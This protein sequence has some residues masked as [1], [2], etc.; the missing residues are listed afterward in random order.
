MGTGK[1]R[2]HRFDRFAH[3]RG[4]PRFDA[5]EPRHLLS[6]V[7]FDLPEYDVPAGSTFDV[8]VLIDLD[9]VTPGDQVPP[10][11]LFSAGIR[12]TF[13][14]ANALVAGAEAVALPVDLDEN[15]LGG[16]ALVEVGPGF[17]GF[18]AAIGFSA[19]EGYMQTLLATITLTDRGSA[20]YPINLELFFDPPT[21]N[22]LD[23]DGTAL[24][25]TLALGSAIVRPDVPEIVL[26]DTAIAVDEGGAGIVNVT[27]SSAPFSVLNLGVAPGP[28]ADPD[29]RSVSDTLTFTPDDWDQP[30]PWIIEA[31]EDDDTEDG[32]TVFTISAP[33]LQPVQLTATERD[34]DVQDLLVSATDL[35]SAESDSTSFTVRLA[36]RPTA[37]VEVRIE[38][39]AGDDPDLNADT[40]LLTF[41]PDDWDQPRTVVVTGSADADDADGTARFDV[42]SDGLD[43]RTVTVTEIDDDEQALVVS[44]TTLTVGEG[45][46]EIV[47]VRLATQPPG[48]VTVQ[49]AR[50]SGDEGLSS[51]VDSVLLGAANWDQPQPVSILA[52]EDDDTQDG[53]ATFTFSAPDL[54][55]RNVNVTV[56]DND[57]Q[58]LI[59]SPSLLA[60]AED[61]TAPLSI[62]LAARPQDDVIVQVERRSGDADVSV[63]GTPITFTANNWFTAQ[64]V[65][66][67]AARDDDGV[68][69]I[70]TLAVIAE[71]VDDVLVVV[72]EV[73]DGLPPEIADQ[74]FAVTDGSAAGTVVGTVDA[75]D[76]DAGDVVT[77]D[78]AAGNDAGAFDIDPDGTLRL[79]DPDALAEVGL[80]TLTVRATDAAG[81]FSEAAV[82]IEIFDGVLKDVFDDLVG[83]DLTGAVT[84]VQGDDPSNRVAQMTEQSDAAIARLVDL[85]DDADR[86]S[87]DYLFSNRGDGDALSIT[88]D[89]IEVFRRV[90]I[91]FAGEDLLST[92]PI[93]VAA[94]AGSAVTLEVRLETTGA[95]GAQ[96]Q[97]DNLEIT[98]QPILTLPL[99]AGRRVMFTDGDGTDV[100]L[101]LSKGDGT[102]TVAGENL[103][104]I[105]E[106]RA[107]TIAGDDIEIVGIDLAGETERGVLQFRGRGGDGRIG[108]RGAINVDG[109]LNALRAGMVVFEHVI[110]T[111]GGPLTKLEAERLDHVRLFV[112]D[113]AGARPL[114]MKFDEA[115]QLHVASTVAM[116]LKADRLAGGSLDAPWF[117][118]L[119]VR[120][121][122]SFS[123]FATGEGAPRDVAV[124][125]GRFGRLVDGD[126]QVEGGAGAITADEI[127]QWTARFTGPVTSLKARRHVRDVDLEADSVRSVAAGTDMT[128]TTI[129]LTRD[130]NPDRPRDVAVRDLR[131]GDAMENVLVTA[132]SGI[133]SLQAGRMEDTVVRVG[134]A[135]TV[136]VGQSPVGPQDFV[137]AAQISSVRLRGTGEPGP[138]MRNVNLAATAIGR[139]TTGF[140]DAAAASTFTAGAFQGLS[141]RDAEGRRGFNRRSDVLTVVGDHLVDP[142][143]LVRVV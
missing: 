121:D 102:L 9:D 84:V 108:L 133:R 24:D 8:Q 19:T 54:P 72:N 30:H 110:V 97:I 15:G 119:Q 125:Q 12:L 127:E 13:D 86:L 64:T 118:R 134:V 10:P 6:G 21:D 113:A 104:T 101:S 52:A 75:T 29:L 2:G 83:Y 46:S 60:V 59:V 124:R 130:F 136:P 78:I 58:R 33:G 68:D 14:D 23:F 61:G 95:P 76:P 57:Q 143:L 112:N 91:D 92:G 74:G 5:L 126:W 3:A 49:I 82:T 135:D 137:T 129:D 25:G 138:W 87:L 22:F 71:S 27:L 44:P 41:T 43:G 50:Q 81:L 80:V 55:Q 51:A 93:D 94:F 34:D 100:T 67:Q 17:A 116:D 7:H 141:Y 38:K 1:G 105:E 4:A 123:L 45:Q 98:S 107:T 120:E 109:A 20:P 37:A 90:G 36:A 18:A 103:A 132:R 99:A 117:G 96:L 69:G 128:A 122:A 79:V 142:G 42:A 73:D 88:I 48:D 26:D 70:A 32:S 111:I 106:R 53:T 114:R 35:A 131:A 62:V 40:A 139:I 77:F 16:P 56:G 28:G 115:Q 47:F 63:T 31:D 66:V 11:G 89:D 39:R 140:A 85:P 65:D